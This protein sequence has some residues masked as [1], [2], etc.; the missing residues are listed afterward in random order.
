MKIVF[1]NTSS[2]SR[3]RNQVK[4]DDEVKE[5]GKNVGK[6]KVYSKSYEKIFLKST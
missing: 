3:L 1:D 4:D 6:K 2:T 5:I